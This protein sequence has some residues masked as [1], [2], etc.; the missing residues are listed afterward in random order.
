MR[1]IGIL[2]IVLGGAVLAYGGLS[3]TKGRHS[4]DIG[5]VQISTATKGFITPAAGAFM[6]VIGVVLVAAG[7]RQTV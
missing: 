6:L 5:P 3:Y 2:L 1:F 7:R 4:T